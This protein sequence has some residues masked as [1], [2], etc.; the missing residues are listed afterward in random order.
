MD[1]SSPVN[2]APLPRISLLAPFSPMVH[3]FPLPGKVNR[4][5]VEILSE[6]F[7]IVMEDWHRQHDYWVL[8]YQKALMLVCRH[9]YAVMLSTP[10]VRSTLRIRRATQKEVIQTFLQ[11]RTR[12]LMDVI[13]DI[14]DAE[15]GNDFNADNFHAC[16]M[17]AAQAASRWRSLKLIS[18]PPHGEFNSLQILQPLKQ[19]ESFK[20]AQGFGMFVDLLMNAISRTATPHF[21]T[22]ELADPVAV[23][24]IVQPACLRIS[25]SLVTLEIRLSKRMDSLVDVLPHLQRLETFVA[26]HLCLPIYPPDVLLP[27]IQTLHKLDLKS[28]SVQWM[29]GH[30][31]PHL[32]KCSI[33]FPHHAGAIQ[34]LQ[35][36]TMPYCFDL[37]YTSNDLSPLKHFHL[38]SLYQVN[39]KSGQ[40][41]AWRGNPQLVAVHHILAASAQSLE[42]LNLDVLCSEQLLVNIL[43]LLP[44]L[45]LLWLGLASPR[46]LSEAFFQAFILESEVV[47]LPRKTIAPL[48]TSLQELRL[49]YRRW[50]RGPDKRS[51]LLAFA[52]IEKSRDLVDDNGDEERFELQLSFEEAPKGCHWSIIG[53]DCNILRGH[54][55]ILIISY[56]ISSPDDRIAMTTTWSGSG[57]IP[58]PFKE[59][60][61][62]YLRNLHDG[63]IEFVY[64]LDHMELMRYDSDQERL[65]TPPDNLPL[66]HALK[67]LVIC[68]IDPSFLAGHTFHKL[69]GCMVVTEYESDDIPGHGLFTEMPVCTKLDINDLTFLSTFKLPHIHE[70]G[71]EFGDLKC[72]TTWEKQIAVNTNLSGLKL[73]H[74]K[75]WHFHGNLDQILRPLPLLNTLVLSFPPDME[76]FGSLLPLSANEASELKQSSSEGRSPV[77]FC[78][79]LQSLQ[80]EGADPSE[81]PSLIPILK[82]L[83][84]GRA[85]F[86]S[87][88]KTFTFSPFRNNYGSKFELIGSDGSFTME[89]CVL[90]AYCRGFELDI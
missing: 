16:F 21:T 48:C 14:N 57:P 54:E 84:I 82:E 83:V 86:G 66:F 90:D 47:R 73:L 80:I 17:A 15:D 4:I 41:S 10:G 43:R 60:E 2:Q 39:V 72:N 50:L 45:K 70:L 18:P 31:F 24:F 64:A 42:Y 12:W 38:P 13:V 23:P 27:L 33:I 35:P 40:W 8:S 87:P 3:P 19:L 77:V 52:A 1:T 44:N 53:R 62:L 11:A 59:E 69:E 67:R 78:P 34:A 71:V 20:L 46:V 37:V 36:I 7:L 81:V 74:L 5:P 79:E 61:D 55:A 89:N 30:I 58:L 65:P 29:A 22:M 9:W 63:P 85:L 49:H 32:E 56:G 76:C 6:I 75:R 26:H 68:Q 25:H 88:L 28:V 51:L